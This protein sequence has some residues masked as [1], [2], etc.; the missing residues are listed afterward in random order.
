[1]PICVIRTAIEQIR[2]GSRRF[3]HPIHAGDAEKAASSRRTPKR[4]AR[5]VDLRL[6]TS[7]PIRDISVI[8]GQKFGCG[9]ALWA[10]RG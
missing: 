3:F 10:I 7:E 9:G 4:F 2:R 6:L 5:N 1:M 8:R